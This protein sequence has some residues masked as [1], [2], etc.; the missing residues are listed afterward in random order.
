MAGPSRLP[1]VSSYDLN[2]DAAEASLRKNFQPHESVVREGYW[3]ARQQ[4]QA[5]GECVA[6][7]QSRTGKALDTAEGAYKRWKGVNFVE[8][9]GLE[10]LWDTSIAK[11]S[12]VNDTGNVSSPAAAAQESIDTSQITAKRSDDVTQ[13]PAKN[14]QWSKRVPLPEIK[15]E[16]VVYLTADSDETIDRLEEGKT[17][18]IG[19]VVDR[20]RYKVCRYRA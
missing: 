13:G 14:S 8:Y 3:Q 2:G 9:G 11:P 5:R 10:A 17:Y 1:A 4:A 18:V 15:K 7:S 6:F 12:E 16:D 20:N 19:A